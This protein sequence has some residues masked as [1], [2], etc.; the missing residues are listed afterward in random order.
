MRDMDNVGSREKNSSTIGFNNRQETC[1]LNFK[2]IIYTFSRFTQF[3]GAG[4]S[5]CSKQ[6]SR[7]S[8]EARSG[9]RIPENRGRG[10]VQRVETK[11][12]GAV[13]HD[14]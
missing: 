11:D 1:L 14:L 4:S 10:G 12:R 3:A 2:M 5:S 13:H 9:L 7:S 6:V 8:V